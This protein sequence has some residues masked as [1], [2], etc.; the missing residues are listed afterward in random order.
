M[1]QGR[2]YSIPVH[3]AGYDS[4][5]KPV[6]SVKHDKRVFAQTADHTH[7]YNVSPRPMRGG[8]RL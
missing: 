2:G 3:K 5:K 1:P 4:K 7:K 6:S 8:F